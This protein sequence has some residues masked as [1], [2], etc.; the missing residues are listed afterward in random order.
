MKKIHTTLLGASLL[1]LATTAIAADST[2]A[3]QPVTPASNKPQVL[4]KPDLWELVATDVAKIDGKI[5]TKEDLSKA[6]AA[7]FPDGKIPENIT[8]QQIVSAAPQFLRQHIQT[9]LLVDL[10]KDSGVQMD[11]DIAYKQMKAEW[12]SL[13]GQEA[14]Q[15]KAEL[16]AKNTTL[17][18]YA[19]ELASKPAIQD[20]LRIQNWLKKKLAEQPPVTDADI[21]KFY[22]DNKSRLQPVDGKAPE[23][24]VVAPQIRA[25][26][27]NQKTQQFLTAQLANAEKSR[28]VE[29][30]LAVPPRGF[31]GCAPSGCTPTCN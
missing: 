24:D 4:L 20:T 5:M 2:S 13:K 19:K 17:D 22:D 26:L 18:N 8:Q 28:K 25:Y 9:M 31:G 29:Y 1:A 30:L 27:E 12:E 16:T 7:Q 15:L 11:A 23:F 14:E 3:L 10:A 21:R 6:F